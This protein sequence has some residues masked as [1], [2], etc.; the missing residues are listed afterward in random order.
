MVIAEHLRHH[1]PFLGADLT[2]GSTMV[3]TPPQ[4]STLAGSCPA[5]SACPRGNFK[6]LFSAGLPR[7]TS[8]VFD[9]EVSCILACLPSVASVL[10]NQSPSSLYSAHHNKQGYLSHQIRSMAWMLLS[11]MLGFF[12]VLGF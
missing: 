3:L 6:N 11:S 10:P 4:Q 9:I 5:D 8:L 12:R 2:P 1:Q 7:N